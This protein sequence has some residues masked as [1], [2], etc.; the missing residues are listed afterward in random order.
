MKKSASKITAFFVLVSTTLFLTAGCGQESQSNGADTA[1]QTSAGTASSDLSENPPA[2][3]GTLEFIMQQPDLNDGTYA[4]YEDFEAKTGVKISIE[5]LPTEQFGNLVLARA[6]TNDLADL[7]G[8]HVGALLRALNPEE[9]LIDITN[10]E[11]INNLDGQFINSVTVNGKI[12]G[13]P[14]LPINGGGV[15]YNKKVYEGLGLK[16]PKTWAELMDNCQAILDGGIIPVVGTFQVSSTAQMIWLSDFYNVTAAVPNFAEEYTA[17]RI[18]LAETP[19][20]VRSFEKMEE[21]YKRGFYNKDYLSTGRDDGLAK[22]A[23]GEAAHYFGLTREIN[24]IATNTP[25]YVEDIGFFPLPSDDA[26]IDGLTIWVP[27]GY[28]ICKTTKNP[29]GAR[30]FQEY[31]SSSDSVLAYTAKMAPTG[32]FLVKN[33]EMPKDIYPAIQTAV[34]YVENGKTQAAQEFVSPIKGPNTPQICVEASTGVKSPLEAAEA[35]DEDNA[36]FAKQL[37]LEGW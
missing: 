16:V 1:Q 34:E 4:Q 6:A 19:V 18:R 10:E 36:K 35:I 3:G 12:Y 13:T 29:E 11:F 26:G 5:Q 7:L 15:V 8:Y 21:V 14:V 32:P 22:L 20:Y 30:L 31:M 24:N 33:V 2:A 25:E 17:N 37:G 28:Y 9:N 27:H 23:R